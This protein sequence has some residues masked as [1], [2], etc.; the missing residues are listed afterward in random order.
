MGVRSVLGL[1][2]GTLD[3]NMADSFTLSLSLDLQD[4]SG[5]GSGEG[6]VFSFTVLHQRKPADKAIQRRSNHVISEKCGSH[7]RPGSSTFRSSVL[8]F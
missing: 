4:L 1:T 7:G 5:E 3:K 6:E 8:P 2:G